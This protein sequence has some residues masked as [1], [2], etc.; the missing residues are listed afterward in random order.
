MKHEF[1]GSDRS[2]A[3][4]THRIERRVLTRAFLDLL[5]RCPALLC[6]SALTFLL[7]APSARAN[8]AVVV[9]PA[10]DT[11]APAELLDAATSELMRLIRVHGFDVI[12][13]GQASVSAED[14]Q[15][16]G[17]FP[18]QLNPL[19][20]RSVECAVE[21]RRLFDAS[22]AAQLMLSGLA[23]KL[24]SVTVTITESASA[25]FT[26]SAPVEGGDSKGAVQAAYG[27]A[28]DKYVRGEGPWLSIAGGPAGALVL[29]DGQE[30][31]NLPIER[32]YLAPG[33]H[34]VEVRAE[35]H[36]AQ[37]VALKIPTRIDHEERLNVTLAALGTK[38]SKEHA[39]DRTWDYVTGGLIAAAGAAH[40]SVGVFQ[41]LKRDECATHDAQ[42]CTSYYGDDEGIAQEKLL[43]G[44]GAAG[45]AVGALWMGLGPIARLSVRADARS[46]ALTVH[47]AF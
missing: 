7:G 26:A 10:T 40:L 36:A 41:L 27:S 15:Q 4:E 20:C 39:L 45:V 46:A 22:F 33:A 32:R 11:A 3:R 44:L 43:I 35:G 13:P 19:D 29:V 6:A 5:A 12:S 17:N 37:V 18:A 1:Q 9:P 21:Y 24:R 16:S 23:G 8:T 47:G 34:R 25:T 14:A 42:G 30:Y 2:L 28:R 38:P 31:G